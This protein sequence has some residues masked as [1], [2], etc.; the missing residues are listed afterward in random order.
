[1]S[2][3]C[4]KT[5]LVFLEFILDILFVRMKEINDDNNFSIIKRMA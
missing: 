2:E 5:G 1:M 4:Y 3:H